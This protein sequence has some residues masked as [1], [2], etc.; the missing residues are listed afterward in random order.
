[1]PCRN[2]ALCG[3]TIAGP[4][5]RRSARTFGVAT[6]DLIFQARP[7]GR[8]ADGAT[9]AP[10]F[11]VRCHIV[12]VPLPPI[13]SF[14]AWRWPGEAA[15]ECIQERRSFCGAASCLSSSER[16]SPAMA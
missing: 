6:D 11:S 3:R 8:G 15:R 9:Q 14:K 13:L 12:P 5:H 1:M 2:V 7:A 16:S 10:A 4:H